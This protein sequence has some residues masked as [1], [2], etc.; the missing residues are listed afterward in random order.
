MIELLTYDGTKVKALKERQGIEKALGPRAGFEAR[1]EREIREKD[2]GRIVWIKVSRPDEHDLSLLERDFDIPRSFLQALMTGHYR[3][4]VRFFHKYTSMTL[5]VP[6]SARGLFKGG[7][8]GGSSAYHGE[9]DVH[10]GGEGNREIG[11][12]GIE[13]FGI[14]GSTRQVVHSL[15]V[16][17]RLVSRVDVIWGAD[18]LITIQYGEAAAINEFWTEAEREIALWRNGVESLLTDLLHSCV[19][20]YFPI[21][22]RIEDQIRRIEL[23]VYKDA[24]RLALER[25]FSL[26]REILNLRKILSRQRNAFEA[27]SRMD[28]TETSLPKPRLQDVFEHLL[29]IIDW[30]EDYQDSLSITAEVNVSMISNRLNSIMKVLTVIAT[31]MMPLTVITGIYGMNFKY[32]PELYWKYGYFAVLGVMGAITIGMI[33]YFRKRGWF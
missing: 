16:P 32:M 6:V 28:E 11:E 33:H 25:I 22:D 23:Q 19:E 27:I 15:H 24:G 26:K 31:V 1:A 7:R 20:D 17:R 13:D 10:Y 9:E 30:I 8:S 4:G 21:L 2:N 5:Y 18:F 12:A 14:E 3:S 29:L